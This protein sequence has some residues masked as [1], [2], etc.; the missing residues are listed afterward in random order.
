MRKTKIQTGYLYH[1]KYEFF[2]IVNDDK[3]MQNH[4]PGKKSPTYFTIND[5]E[6]LWFISLSSKVE[7]YIEHLHTINGISIKVIDSLKFEI[8]SKFNN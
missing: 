5:N 3:L 8:L 7:K 1:I 6:I 2:D 4:E